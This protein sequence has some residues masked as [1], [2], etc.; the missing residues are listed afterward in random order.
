FSDDLGEPI[1]Y[2]AVDDETFVGILT[3]AGVPEDYARM[4]ASIFYPVRE[5]WTAAVTDAVETLTGTSPR[6][7]ETYAR[8]HIADLTT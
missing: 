8:D 1:A 7:L 5:G 3:G 4:L 6:S 2:K